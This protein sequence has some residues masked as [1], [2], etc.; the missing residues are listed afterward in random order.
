MVKLPAGTKTI[1]R[2][3][4]VLVRQKAISLFVTNTGP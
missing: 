4:A 2:K 3:G 1:P